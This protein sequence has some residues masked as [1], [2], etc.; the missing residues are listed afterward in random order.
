MPHEL[1]NLTKKKW[2]ELKKAHNMK[3][4]G[5]LEA[6]FTKLTGIN[7]GDHI[8]KFRKAYDAAAKVATTS[9]M[10][11]VVKTSKAL[12]KALRDYAKQKEFSTSE[13]KEFKAAVLKWA[14]EAKDYCDT[15]ARVAKENKEILAQ[16]ESD[17]M[18]EVLKK[19]NLV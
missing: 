14:D 1:L 12:E 19:N 16:N 10:A 8:E 4:K 15:Y 17:L 11:S 3:K 6:F 2:E 7:V 5:A 9:T 18:I 13:A